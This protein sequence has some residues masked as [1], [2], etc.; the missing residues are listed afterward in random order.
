MAV[1]VDDMRA[2]YGRMVMCHMLADSTDE[3]LD[4]AARIGV[5][6]RWIQDRGT[7]HEHFDICLSK[8]RK[9]VA[10]GAREISRREV[11]ALIAARRLVA[12]R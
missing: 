5:S 2:N 10:L 6:A 1:Y 9:A 11:G 3:L 8:R 12:A 7:A 4:M